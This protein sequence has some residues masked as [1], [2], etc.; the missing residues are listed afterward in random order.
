MYQNLT[1]VIEHLTSSLGDFTVEQMAQMK[2]WATDLREFLQTHREQAT[3]DMQRQ[4][5]AVNGALDKVESRV[6]HETM[7][8]SSRVRFD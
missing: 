2:T 3:E 4:A 5:E 7:N 1:Q 8:V 6:S